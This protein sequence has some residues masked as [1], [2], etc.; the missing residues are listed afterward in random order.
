VNSNFVASFLNNCIAGIV[1]AIVVLVGLKLWRQYSAWKMFA[2]VAGEYEEC[3]MPAGTPTTGTVKIRTK[4]AQLLTQG[5]KKDGHVEW[6]GIINMNPLSPNVGDG[7]YNAVGKFDCGV[8]HVQR[9]PE[10]KNFVVMGSNTSD[11]E[12]KERFNML[13]RRKR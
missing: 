4:G 5:I 3:T 7:V 10:T 6:A 8:H 11:P 9:D 2:P 13:W 12:G 1:S